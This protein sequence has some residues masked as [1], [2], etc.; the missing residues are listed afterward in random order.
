MSNLFSGDNVVL[1]SHKVLIV[2]DEVLIALDL[3]DIV[4]GAG[5]AVIGPAVTVKQAHEHL[6][7][8]AVTA[9]ILDVN[10]GNENS[11]E[12]ARRLR[13]AGIPFIYHSGHFDEGNRLWP[14]APLARKPAEPKTLIA[15]LVK[16]TKANSAS[17]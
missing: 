4:C 2:E 17:R 10:L 8:N 14:L 15:A 13:T 3:V 1:S 7:A 9:A 16:A 6:D 5:A 11:L 12:V